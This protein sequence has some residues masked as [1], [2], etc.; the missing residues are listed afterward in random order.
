[1]TGSKS[2]QLAINGG[3]PVR[4]GSLPSVGSIS[5]RTFG[6]EEIANLT[7]VI[8]SGKLFRFGGHF[9]QDFEKGLAEL[10]VMNHAV[11]V[12]SGTAAIHTA[13]AVLDFEP[14]DEV[15]VPPIT[16]MG[17]I[18]PILALNG[19]PVFADVDERTL[20]LDPASVKERVTGRTRAILAVHL[21]GNMCDIDAL[22]EIARSCGA[23]L[24]EDCAQ[25]YLAEDNGRL[26]G[27]SGAISAFSLQQSKHIASGDGGAVVT[28]DPDLASKAAMFMDKGWDRVTGG[29][30]YLML[31]LN[32]RMNELTGAVAAAQLSKV[33]QVV[34]NRRKWAD[35]LTSQIAGA[36]NVTPPYARPGVKH[37]YWFYALRWDT[38]ATGVSIGDFCAALGAEGVPAGAGY[39]QHPIFDTPS[40]RARKTYGTSSY[41]YGQAG[42]DIVYRNEDVPGACRAM[43]RLAVIPMNENYTQADVSAIAEAIGKV[44]GALSP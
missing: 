20:C 13:L 41:P 36:P 31:G 27:T 38:D 9:V 11:A 4:T 21:A 24:V 5:G 30:E 33:R 19:I 25:C 40:M 35:L 12:T 6:D 23:A 37:S 26:S 32:Y 18:A 1:M 8:R 42:R 10:L 17:S 2:D 22:G 34:E 28:N 3:T 43:D 29:R 15:I 7:E 39:I 14:G 16:D 44:A